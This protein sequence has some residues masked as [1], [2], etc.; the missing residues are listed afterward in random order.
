[1]G[2]DISE[3]RGHGEVS[4]DVH[5]AD[6][7]GLRDLDRSYTCSGI[8]LDGCWER[9]DSGTGV[10]SSGCCLKVALSDLHNTGKGVRLLFQLHRRQVGCK[11]NRT[12]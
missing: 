4:P 1:M 5:M 12:W 3:D 11:I 6:W 7:E 9:R 8:P 10:A 2:R